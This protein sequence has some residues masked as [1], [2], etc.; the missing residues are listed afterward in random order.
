[1]MNLHRKFIK[2]IKIKKRTLLQ[3]R[4]LKQP[5]AS[6]NNS[7]LIVQIISPPV[8]FGQILVNKNVTS[9]KPNA[10]PIN[11]NA[12]SFK[13]SFRQFHRQSLKHSSNP[14]IL[15]I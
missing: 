11:N 10:S 2:I 13:A 12:P 4:R 1:M 6:S 15:R 14:T 8:A 7:F 9:A 3:L 5:P